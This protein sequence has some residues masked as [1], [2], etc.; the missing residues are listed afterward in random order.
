MLTESASQRHPS[1]AAL[2][3]AQGI[4]VDAYCTL[5]GVNNL[6]SGH[7]LGISLTYPA[8]STISMDYTLLWNNTT[9]YASGVVHTNDRSGDPAFVDPAAWDYHVGAG[10]A[11]IDQ[12]TDAGVTTDWD[13]DVRPQGSGYDIGADEYTGALAQGHYA[14]LSTIK[15]HVP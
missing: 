4:L 10:S 5:D 15:S 2:A 9:D 14:I 6:L 1:A 11:A 13:G 3:E 12:G 8:S 7:T